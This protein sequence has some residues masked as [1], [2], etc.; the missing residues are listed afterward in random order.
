MEN[1]S[2]IHCII[3]T[4]N[5]E[6]WIMQCLESVC[7]STLKINIIV[8]DNLSSD[9]TT[10]IIDEHFPSVTLIRNIANLGFGKANN[11]GLRHAY[12]ENGEY[13][14]LLNQDARV[15]PDT[16]E[17]MVQKLQVNP[18]YGILSPMQFYD[19]YAL[20]RKF[21]SYLKGIEDDLQHD[22][23]DTIQEKIYPLRFVNAA[24]WLMNRACIEK[25]GLFAPIFDHYGEDLNYAHRCNYHQVKIGVFPKAIAYHERE[26]FPPVEKGIL[27]SKLL[28]RDKHYC[29]GVLLNLKHSYFR[30]WLFLLFTSLKEFLISLFL[31]RLKTCVVIINRLKY[32]ALFSKFISQRKKMTQQSAFL[33]DE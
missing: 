5:A 22:L 14:F 4:Y 20:D 23:R 8:I 24:V 1:P 7:N 31:L 29:L 16:I 27:L 15:K 3:A 9:R 26:Q 17:I 25:V 19:S 11:I 18:E 28:M 2:K 21:K 10:Q 12:Q 6:A 33:F 13:F 30:Q 32:V